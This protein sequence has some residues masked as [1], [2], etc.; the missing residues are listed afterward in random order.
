MWGNW[1]T[2]YCTSHRFICFLSW[3]PLLTHR[4]I[5][6]HFDLWEN[7]PFNNSRF[8]HVFSYVAV[9]DIFLFDLVIDIFSRSFFCTYRWLILS[10]RNFVYTCFFHINALAH[11][12]NTFLLGHILPCSIWLWTKKIPLISV[13]FVQNG[14]LRFLNWA[15]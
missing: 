4:L 14:K 11:G 2:H 6:I 9:W 12:Q 5:L 7:F 13:L 15:C 10:T 8:Y 1:S 3:L